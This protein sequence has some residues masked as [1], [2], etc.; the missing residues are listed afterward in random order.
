[1]PGYRP[2][3][4][5]P[6]CADRGWLNKLSSRVP[7]GQRRAVRP[8][9]TSISP[10]Y[11]ACVEQLA[12]EHARDADRLVSLEQG[13]AGQGFENAAL[14]RDRDRRESAERAELRLRERAAE[15]DPADDWDQG[16]L[17]F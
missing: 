13:W 10:H 4:N 7:I 15:L 3:P 11:A 1:M 14:R 5:D 16:S 17:F 6:R 2:I 12:A 9:E 8:S